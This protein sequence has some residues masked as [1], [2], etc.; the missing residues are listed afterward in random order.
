[1][2]SAESLSRN[3]TSG[4]TRLGDSSAG[5][6]RRDRSEAHTMRVCATGQTAL[7]RMPLV[8]RSSAQDRV[9]E[10]TAPLV[11]EYVASLRWPK[12]A[13]ELML[14]ID[15]PVPCSRMA[16]MAAVPQ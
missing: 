3:S 5:I 11:A 16:R 15:P 8:S 14:T 13:P 7:T 12:K 4:A 1:M 9:S 10:A 6:E 2:P